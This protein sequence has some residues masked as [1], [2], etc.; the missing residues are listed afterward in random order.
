M[1][2]GQQDPVFC[3]VTGAPYS[4]SPVG[5]LPEHHTYFSP[6]HSLPFI[7]PYCLMPVFP[8]CPPQNTS[9]PE[10]RIL[11]CRT[12]YGMQD[13]LY[14]DLRNELRTSPHAYSLKGSKNPPWPLIL[15]TVCITYC[16]VLPQFMSGMLSDYS[17]DKHNTNR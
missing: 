11:M 1:G 15:L 4:K 6:Q 8:V 14:K 16:N 10:A 3:L 7:M 17:F 5:H 2:G 9:S 13:T 12:V